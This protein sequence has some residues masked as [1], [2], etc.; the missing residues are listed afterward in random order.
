MSLSLLLCLR[1]PRTVLWYRRPWRNQV[2]PYLAGIMDASFFPSVQTTIICAAQQTGKSE[3]VH[4][5]IGYAIDR[6]PGPVLYVYPDEKT[7]GKT[8]RTASSP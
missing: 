8:A 3:S 2:T 1:H 7:A 5:C 6:E 4:N